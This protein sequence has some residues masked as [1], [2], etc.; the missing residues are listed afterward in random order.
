MILSRGVMVARRTA[1]STQSPY[2][3][4][5]SVQVQVLAGQSFI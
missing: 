2:R 3:L 5:P 1:D 4:D